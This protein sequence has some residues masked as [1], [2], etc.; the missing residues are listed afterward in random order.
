MATD[1]R[2]D[3]RA[4]E[5]LIR[6]PRR[7]RWFH[8]AIYLLT[9]PLIWTGGWLLFGEEAHPSLLAR[10][11]GVADVRLHVWVGRT[12]LVLIVAVKD[13]VEVDRVTAVGLTAPIVA[14][15]NTITQAE[16][17]DGGTLVIAGLR[18]ENSLGDERGI[19]SLS[20]IPVL[21]WLVS[22]LGSLYSLYLFFL[23]APIL[24]K[25]PE[26]KVVAY[27]AVVVVVAIAVGFAIAM[28]NASIIGMGAV[29][30]VGGMH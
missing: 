1:I 23:G 18:Q 9:I 17:I 14:T 6:H 21:G 20:K 29:G 16:I 15:R 12:F 11:F 5:R 19:P 26:A 22:L 28:I 8:S 27:T 25:V 4:G 13:E 2:R 10:A 30:M 3:R 7:V 24:M